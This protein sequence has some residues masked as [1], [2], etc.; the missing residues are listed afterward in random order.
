MF[1]H[2]IRPLSATL[3]SLA[4]A[5]T[6]AGLAAC[7]AGT[8]LA[9]Q[10]TSPTVS[11]PGATAADAATGSST[12]T[13]AA[14]SV[15]PAFA[16]ASAT[17]SSTAGSSASPGETD[18]DQDHCAM[19]LPAQI[20]GTP[21]VAPGSIDGV[22]A[23]HDGTGW[24]LRVTHPGTGAEVFTGAIRSAQAITAHPYA[25]EKG[26]SY[27]LSPDRH[28]LTFTMTNHGRIDGIDFTD[29]CAVSTQF[30]FQHAGAELPAS[31]VHLGAHGVAPATDPFIIQRQK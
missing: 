31:A 3:A 11:A 14:A 6:V 28:Q 19:P 21:T 26:D 16:A 27:Q 20:V 18:A 5:A 8:P 1:R 12:G 4:A 24:H 25:L 29:D 13:P 17:A 10:A 30:G 7:Q 15:Q 23:W 9:A 22:W 2:H